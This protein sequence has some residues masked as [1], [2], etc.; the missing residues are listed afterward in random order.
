MSSTECVAVFCTVNKTYTDNK[1]SSLSG[2][3]TTRE[4][5]VS[6]ILKSSVLCKCVSVAAPAM[7]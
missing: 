4:V 3:L 1:T 5:T 6:A 2:V 7:F